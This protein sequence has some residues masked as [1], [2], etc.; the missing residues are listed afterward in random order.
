MNVLPEFAEVCIS[1]NSSENGS[2]VAE[3]WKE[4]VP[5]SRVIFI[6]QQYVAQI[7]REDRF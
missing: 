5:H 2:K 3:H 4:M 7:E 6:K 1:K